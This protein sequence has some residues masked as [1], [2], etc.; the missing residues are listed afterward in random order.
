MVFSTK[1][2]VKFLK[3]VLVSTYSEVILLTIRIL[4]LLIIV[5]GIS[6]IDLDSNY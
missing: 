6:L 2:S 1:R 5:F 3:I 4:S